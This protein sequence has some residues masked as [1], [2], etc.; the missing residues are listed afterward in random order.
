[1]ETLAGNFPVNFTYY[2][3]TLFAILA[4][5]WIVR[6]HWRRSAS[7]RARR[8][9]I[10]FGGLLGIRLLLLLAVI[11]VLL[12]GASDRVWLPPL[13]RT[14]SVISLALLGWGF[15]PLLRD[16][17]G[18]GLTF[19]AANIGLAF[20]FF[21]LTAVAWRFQF[22]ADPTLS[23]NRTIWEVIWLLWQAGLALLAII[24]LARHSSERRSLALFSFASLFLGYVLHAL[25]LSTYS[26]SVPVGVRL[27]EIVAYPILVVAVYQEIIKSLDLRS[28]E[29]QHLSSTSLDKIQG[30]ISL[31]E[32]TRNITASLELF[33]VLEGAAQ[34][35]AH[36]LNADQCAIALPEDG[37]T[38]QLRLMAIH[39]PYREGRGEAV[40]FPLNDQQ[41]IKHALSRMRQIQL[42]ESDDNPQIRLLF[43]LMGAREMGPIIFQPLVQGDTALGVLIVGNA[44]SKRP[45]GA[46][47]AQLCETLARQIAVAID[48]ARTHQALS[49]K[50]QQLAWTLRNQEQES[51]R[52]KAA[53]EAELKKS[54]EEVALFAQRLYE[55]E[56]S[57][58]NDKRALEEAEQRLKV[59]DE[60]IRTAK[61]TLDESK[62]RSRQMEGRL[63]DADRNYQRL[64]DDLTHRSQDLQ[65]LEEERSGLQ[66]RLQV[67]EQEL[68]QAQQLAAELASVKSHARKL[69]RALKQAH[70]RMQ[71][72]A[73]VP[74]ALSSAQASAEFENLSCGVLIADAA[75]RI[76]RAN[77]A[78]TGLLG[79]DAP[80]VIGRELGQLVND[81]RWRELLSQFRLDSGSLL[82]T[83]FHSGDR[84]LRATISPMSDPAES[85]S[86]GSV[87]ILYDITAE[88]HSQ[89]ARDEFVASLSQ[90]L[91]TPMTSITGYTD[92]LVGESVGVIGEMQRKFLQRIKANIERMGSM[93]NDLI[94]VTA[95]DAGQLEIRPTALDM[96]EVIEDTII[97]ARAQLEEKELTLELSLPEQMPLV[98]ADPEYVR[99]IMSNLLGNATKSSPVGGTMEIAAVVRDGPI[100]AQDGLDANEKQYLQIAVRDSGGGIASRDL[101][102]VFDRFYQAERPLVEG[103][104]ETGVGLAIVKS[105][106]EAHGGRV[107]VESEIGLGSIFYFWLPISHPYND[108]WQ[109]IDVPPL[110][111]SND[112]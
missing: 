68:G 50:A 85:E 3:F 58:K 83:T 77:A 106:V 47:E 17:V 28:Q 18:A 43:A 65:E 81:N 56:T 87:T 78:A 62:G 104:G 55:Q 105:L 59:L 97:G 32:A 103:L 4:S 109:E 46:S 79:V 48:N 27:G 24:G 12:L 11:M 60:A 31:F 80:G 6:D 90:E 36:A 73:P 21:L 96:A 107:W 14:V 26:A 70:H 7:F 53:M 52:R 57:S 22:V 86:A 75:G 93:L 94:G 95:I 25:T 99:Q 66:Q 102:R 91:R 100:E 13:D 69:A 61:H 23:F 88:A 38:A 8:L 2:L 41:A 63:Q 64:Q 111:L 35:V 82:S 39:N 49:A 20:A 92:L 10:V 40:T 74:S 30:L 42:K 84:V 37:E 112:E 101:D 1:V 108:P 89:Q 29:L 5:L 16:E 33:D 44:E 98:E 34:S 19:L 51:S 54:R 15:V 9:M 67:M 45:F 110:N 76:N 71:Q 72:A